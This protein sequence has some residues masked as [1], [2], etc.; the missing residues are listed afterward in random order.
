MSDDFE[1]MNFHYLNSFD[2]L[3]F[4]A[5]NHQDCIESQYHAEIR[6]YFFFQTN[7]QILKFLP[8]FFY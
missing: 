7:T 3:F 8:N 5:L 4:S 1:H 2:Q 6:E